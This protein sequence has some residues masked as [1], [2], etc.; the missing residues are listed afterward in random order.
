[1]IK[2]TTIPENLKPFLSPKQFQATF[3][4][5]GLTCDVA[6][7]TPDLS[8]CN[9][10]VWGDWGPMYQCALAPG[11][12]VTTRYLCSAA[13]V[14]AQY[15]FSPPTIGLLSPMLAAERARDPFYLEIVDAARCLRI[16]AYLDQTGQFD[17]ATVERV[18]A[19]TDILPLVFPELCYRRLAP[20]P[21]EAQTWKK[22]A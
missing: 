20:G 12:H 5:Q 4:L 19:G 6:V 8:T 11:L 22:S 3:R 17:R 2:L 18:G 7:Q 21:D 16:K 9:A 14:R 10:S 15:R 1:M 13:E